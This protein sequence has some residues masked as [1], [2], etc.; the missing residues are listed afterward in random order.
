[1]TDED[2]EK[3]TEFLDQDSGLRVSRR[4]QAVLGAVIRDFLVQTIAD[5]IE[6]GKVV[7]GPAS[8]EEQAE[9]V[10]IALASMLEKSALADEEAARAA[11]SVL[12][13]DVHEAADDADAR[14]RTLPDQKR[15]LL[16]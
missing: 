12:S 6:S 11:E 1:M 10:L 9:K 13:A 2:M 15:R 4:E 3:L 14:L 16:H 8:G 7:F 5:P